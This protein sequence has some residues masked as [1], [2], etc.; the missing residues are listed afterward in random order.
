MDEQ[1][2]GHSGKL[3]REGSQAK[4][5]VRVN[6]G[7]RTEIAHTVPALEHRAAILAHQHGEAGRLIIGDR[8]K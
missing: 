2:D 8:A 7:F 6:L 4:I 3:F 1:H 5:R